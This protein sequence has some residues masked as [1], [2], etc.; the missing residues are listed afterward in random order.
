MPVLQLLVSFGMALNH[1]YLSSFQFRDSITLPCTISAP[2][3][4]ELCCMFCIRYYGDG[5]GSHVPVEL[6][7]LHLRPRQPFRARARLL[8]LRVFAVFASLP[9]VEALR[10]ASLH[11]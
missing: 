3:R 5:R 1:V 4:T 8:M 9:P 2:M 6:L 10:G 11:D 7:T